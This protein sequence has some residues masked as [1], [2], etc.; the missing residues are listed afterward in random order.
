MKLFFEEKEVLSQEAQDQIFIDC[1][2]LIRVQIC[3][4][5]L[6]VSP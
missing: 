6:R 5:N 3:K 4:Y 2:L 1:S